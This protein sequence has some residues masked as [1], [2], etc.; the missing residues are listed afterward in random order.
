MLSHPNILPGTFTAY[1]ASSA[2]VEAIYDFWEYFTPIEEA[3]PRNCSA[4]VKT[5]VQYIDGVLSS[6]D[7]GDVATLK[8]RFG[9]SALNDADFADVVSNPLTQ[10]Q[11]NQDA[12]ISFCDHIEG[13]SSNYTRWMSESGRGV[14]LVAALDAYSSYV[15]E[16]INC[17]E[18]GASCDTYD[19]SIV[20][21][22]PN[23]LAD[24]NRQWMWML[25]NEPFGWY[26]T[27]PPK[28]DG[29][30]IISSALRPEH[31]Q[32]RCPLAFP[33]TNGFQAGSVVGFTAEH[34]NMW[35]KGWDAPYER[36][37]FVN[38]EHDPWRSATIA[39][40]SRPGGPVESSDAIPALV[41]EKG[42]HVP[43]LILED[44]SP[45]QTPVIEKAVE[46]MGSWLKDWEKP[47]SSRR[48]VARRRA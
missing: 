29:T 13:V 22:T 28:S 39:A 34:L 6:G 21:N 14:G 26:Q 4:D 18:N 41:V 5:V 3:L 16:N 2:V 48:A 7:A 8:L 40:D 17:G 27:G 10:W 36:V 12:V 23:D 20:W 32:R 46:I 1:H 30:N 42:V 19:D 35:T 43:D 9:L 47:A 37:L 44:D 31:Y 25:C 33:E 45:Y 38:G 24:D 15:R 11:S